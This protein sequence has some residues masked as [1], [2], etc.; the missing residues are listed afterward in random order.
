MI[1]F[2]TQLRFSCPSEELKNPFFS[3][4]SAKKIKNKRKKLIWLILKFYFAAAEESVYFQFRWAKVV[5]E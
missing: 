2:T 4:K 5:V 1:F 3:D